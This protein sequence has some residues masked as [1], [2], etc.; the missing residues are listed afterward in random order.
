MTVSAQGGSVTVA[1]AAGHTVMF[2]PATSGS[3]H[4]PLPAGNWKV[5][6]VQNDPTFNYD[7]DLF[8]D[9]NPAHAKAKLPAGP[10]NP[11]G[12]VWIG[13]DKEHYGIHG[14][15]EPSLDRQDDLPRMRPA[16]QL[17][18]REAGVAREEREHR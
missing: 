7:P 8:W 5:T 15:P 12:V 4:D 6:G 1:D 16:D 3:V 13:L 10:N 2:A 14:T 18:C 11:V 17:G 9:A